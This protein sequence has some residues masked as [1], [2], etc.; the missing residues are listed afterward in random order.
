MPDGGGSIL[1]PEQDFP[2]DDS[3]DD[4]FDPENS[5]NCSCS[6]SRAGSEDEASGATSSYSSLCLPEG[7]LFSE[8][9]ALDERTWKTN[10]GADSNETSDCEII[11]GR[12][13]RKEVNYQKLYDVSVYKSSLMFKKSVLVIEVDDLGCVL[14]FD[15]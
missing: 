15:T 11:G 10:F 9:G 14:Q 4:D 6:H 12:R 13:Q 7:D 8:F 3:E 2:S 5:E 1:D